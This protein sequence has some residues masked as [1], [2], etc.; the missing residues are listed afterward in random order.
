METYHFA[1]AIVG[2][3][4]IGSMSFSVWIGNLFYGRDIRKS[5]SNNAG[6]TNMYR[7]LG[8]KAAIAV[9]ILDI[10][11][12]SLA[13]GLAFLFDIPNDPDQI[14]F[15][16]FL[17]ALS[18]MSGHIFPIYTRFK[19]GKGVATLFGAFIAIHPIVAIALLLIFIIILSLFGYVSLSALFATF[20]FP[21]ISFF[22]LNSS[23]PNIGLSIVIFLF[24][25]ISHHKNIQRLVHKK[26]PKIFSI[27]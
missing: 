8:K 12:G 5:G 9:L 27:K 23:L 6:A 18:A 21:F 20:I 25:V 17:L 22:L 16:K 10:L 1:L 2:A 15:L 3:Y 4:L 26:E 11:K 14:I 19:G 7:V 13:V 24:I